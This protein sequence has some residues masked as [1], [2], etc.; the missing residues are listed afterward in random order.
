M[1]QILMRTE[2]DLGAMITLESQ[3]KSGW[4]KL[5]KLDV[6]L[7]NG[8]GLTAT[9]DFDSHKDLIGRVYLKPQRL[10]RRISMSGGVS[11]FYGGLIQATLY[12]YRTMTE[13]GRPFMQVDSALT[14]LGRLSPRRYYGA[15]VQWKRKNKIGA[16]E[17]R[18]EIIGGLQTGS[19]ASSETPPVAFKNQEGYYVRS[20]LGGYAYL[21]QS[22]FSERHQL[23]LKFDFYDPNTGVKGTQIGLP[24]R[25]SPA[26]ILYYTLGGGYTFYVTDHLKWTL[27]YDHVV[28]EKTTLPG[29]T[30]N[31]PD[32]VLTC[33][34]QFRF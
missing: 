34:L 9:T 24:G 6:G 26:D 30:T 32:D 17:L 2:R 5:I 4:L 25:F 15:D 8:Q 12:V 7:F 27:W 23:G 31:L 16:T 21:L 29:Y 3:R 11:G 28:N 22:I 20:F 18:L 10:S 13:Q 33:R 1:S 19:A 14:Q